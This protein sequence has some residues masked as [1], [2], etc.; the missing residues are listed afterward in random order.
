MP[1][2][3]RRMSGVVLP[4]ASLPGPFGIGDVG[5]QAYAFVDW[6][7]RAGQR[8]WQILPLSIPD[9][10]GSPYASLSGEAGNWLLISPEKLE[11]RGLLPRRGI[12]APH[13]AGAIRYR[14]VFREKWRIIKAAYQHF[15]V[16]GDARQHHDFAAFVDQESDWLDD[17]VLFQALKDRHQQAPWWEWKSVYR[18]AATARQH[19]DDRLRLSMDIHAFAQWVWADQWREL[20][21]YARRRGVQLIGDLPFFVRTDS[22]DV[23]AHPQLFLLNR[24]G[25]PTVVAGVVPDAFSKTGQRWGNPQYHWSAHRRQ[26][27]EWWVR[28]LRVLNERCDWI[29]FDHFRGLMHTWH[30]PAAQPDARRGAWVASPGAQLLRTVKRRIPDIRLIAEDLGPEAVGADHLRRTFHIPTIR[31]MVFGWNGLPNNPHALTAIRPDVV[32][33]TSNHDTDTFAGWWR[34]EARWYERRAFRGVMRDDESV[35][36]AAVRIAAESSAAI[37]LFPVQD[38]LGLGASARIN[39]PGRRRGNWAWRLREGQLDGQTA[40]QLRRLTMRYGR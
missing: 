29:R 35:A 31:L 2:R 38:I 23:W 13:Q 17:Y 36:Q 6:L 22:V 37:A 5:P 21:R 7:A 16:H 12:V 28:R 1:H 26:K 10:T 32:L 40:R 30:I 27:F 18:K 8:A 3:I 34:T 15:Q 25:L 19:L 24:H 20:H 11:A 39:K 4:V 9:S 33:Y 14:R